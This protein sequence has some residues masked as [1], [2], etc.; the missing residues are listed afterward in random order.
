MEK[1]PTKCSL[2]VLKV[3]KSPKTPKWKDVIETPDH[4]QVHV[5]S[6]DRVC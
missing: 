2:G 1:K 3:S 6:W 4:G 5:P